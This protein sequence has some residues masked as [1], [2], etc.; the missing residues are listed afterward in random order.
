MHIIGR[1]AKDIKRVKALV[2]EKSAQNWINDR[3]LKDWKVQSEDL[4]ND[5]NTPK[6]VIVTNPSGFQSIDGYRAVEPKQRIM[7]SQYYGK[8]PTKLARADHNYGSWYDETIRPLIP[9]AV[10]KQLFNKAVQIVLKSMGHSVDENLGRQIKPFVENNNQLSYDWLHSFGK[11]TSQIKGANAAIEEGEQ[12]GFVLNFITQELSYET[13]I[14]IISHSKPAMKK[15]EEE[16][17]QDELEAIQQ[18]LVQGEKEKQ[19]ERF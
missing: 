4:D 3:G 10:G 8:Y 1:L 11:V 19:N 6:N 9:D 5:E 2:N 15:D 12:L 13:A 16:E 14:R 18:S 17:Q 7:L